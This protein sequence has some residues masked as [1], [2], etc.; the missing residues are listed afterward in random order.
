MNLAD[1]H[2]AS[3][4]ARNYAEAVQRIESIRAAQPPGLNPVGCQQFLSHGRPTGRAVV[5]F[6]GY[7]SCPQQFKRLGDQ[8]RSNLVV[9]K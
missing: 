9:G 6:H 1:Y 3:Q 7:T 5:L 4:P 8:Q 2:P